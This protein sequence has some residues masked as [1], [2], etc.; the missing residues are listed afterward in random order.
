LTNLHF[1]AKFA[2]FSLKN[3]MALEKMICSNGGSLSR[4]V[5]AACLGAIVLEP[6]SAEAQ[7]NPD[8][9]CPSPSPNDPRTVGALY[10]QS[11]Q[12]YSCAM[13]PNLEPAEVDNRN[14]HSLFSMYD[15]LT[16]GTNR[17]DP[18]V[19]NG[20]PQLQFNLRQIAMRAFHIAPIQRPL[21]IGNISLGGGTPDQV[22]TR[23]RENES[24]KADNLANINR[25]IDGLANPALRSG[26]P[27]AQGA[28]EVVNQRR[29]VLIHLTQLTDRNLSNLLVALRDSLVPIAASLNVC[30]DARQARVT[31]D[32][33]IILS[34]FLC[35]RASALTYE[36]FLRITTDPNLRGLLPSGHRW[37]TAIR[38]SDPSSMGV[39][40]GGNL[41]ELIAAVNMNYYLLH[42]YI[43]AVLRIDALSVRLGGVAV[44][45]SVSLSNHIDRSRLADVI[46][47]EVSVASP[48][49]RTQ[50][51]V[52]QSLPNARPAVSVVDTRIESPAHIAWR[53]RVAAR[54]GRVRLMRIIGLSAAGAGLAG[55]GIAGGLN[56]A[57]RGEAAGII[58]SPLWQGRVAETNMFV[59]NARARRYSVAELEAGNARTRRYADEYRAAVESHNGIIEATQIAAWTS[60]GVAIFGGALAALADVIAGPVPVEPREVSVPAV[61]GQQ[62]PHPAPAG[63]RT[64][65]E[66]AGVG[67]TPNLAVDAT[68]VNVGATI[69]F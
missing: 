12:W 60:L 47:H 53:Q 2:T 6:S 48:V 63:R 68:G 15:A 36:Q 20:L 66:G 26:A 16:S 3:I 49:A 35:S 39:S 34:E 46:G 44:S 45:N 55:F 25:Y 17:T 1:I 23:H 27:E 11:L 43:H 37:P 67:V 9:I 58:N 14:W 13:A 29:D 40:V 4:A 57:E 41:E 30:G 56:L 69:T 32:Q 42:L 19:L 24:V 18:A 7:T 8:H 22:A 52:Q 31:G 65:V 33:L 51:P 10:R 54:A 62:G 50:V 28:L 64:E 61:P 59:A 38:A 21:A 5:M